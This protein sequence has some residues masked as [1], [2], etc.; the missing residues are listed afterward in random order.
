MH[1]EILALRHQ[2]AVLQRRTSKR[3][4]LRTADRL[5]WVILSRLW[6]QWR[7]ALAIVKPETVI[8][9]AEK[10]V[11]MVLAL[12]EQSREVGSTLR[13]PRNKGANPADECGESTMGS[14]TDSWRVAETGNTGLSG[15]DSQVHD[16]STKATL[17]NVAHFS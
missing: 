17:T 12:E 11:S 10:R 1:I 9:V 6:I 3:P 14:A 7:S 16:A 15:D 4:S 5:R 13:Q 8:G 2:L